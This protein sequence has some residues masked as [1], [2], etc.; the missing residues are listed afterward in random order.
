[1]NISVVSA[2]QEPTVEAQGNRQP[3]DQERIGQQQTDQ[4]QTMSAVAEV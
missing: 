2:D 3:S 4:A 1:V